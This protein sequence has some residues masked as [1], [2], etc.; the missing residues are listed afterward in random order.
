M[1]LKNLNNYMVGFANITEQGI[2]DHI[3]L[4][5]GRITA[6]DPEK[7]FY[8]MQTTWDNQKLVETLFKKIY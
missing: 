7:N 4:S 6:V 1:Y 3:L 2:L 5:Y 8:N